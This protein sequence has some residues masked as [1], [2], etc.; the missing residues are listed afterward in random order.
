MSPTLPVDVKERVNALLGTG[1]Y[2]S[3]EEI[4]TVHRFVEKLAQLRGIGFCSMGSWM[5]RHVLDAG[6]GT[7]ASPSWSACSRR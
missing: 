1:H 4:V 3:E 5:D 7:L 2:E 6:S